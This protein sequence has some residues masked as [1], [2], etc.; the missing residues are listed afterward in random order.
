MQSGECSRNGEKARVGGG[1]VPREGHEMRARGQQ[2]PD[3][4]GP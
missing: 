4:A 1:S 3:P 2:R